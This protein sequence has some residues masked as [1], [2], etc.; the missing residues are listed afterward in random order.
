MMNETLSHQ[1][2][3]TTSY[4]EHALGRFRD[5]VTTEVTHIKVLVE[6]S[7][8]N[9]E[10]A[11]RDVKNV[12]EEA[13]MEANRGVNEVQ[14]TLEIMMA[15]H[16]A[17]GN[18]LAISVTK[19]NRSITDRVWTL[20]RDVTD[21]I[22]KSQGIVSRGQTANQDSTRAMFDNSVA[23]VVKSSN[24]AVNEHFAEIQDKLTTMEDEREDLVPVITEAMQTI[25][26]DGVDAIRT[27]MTV[28]IMAPI[29]G[30]YATLETMIESCTRPSEK[31]SL[32]ESM[33]PAN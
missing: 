14:K 27:D 24:D 17:I 22:R 2:D 15:G 8:T 30:Q 6:D 28:T 9:N 18:S 16:K 12:A 10:E 5:D 25:V 3:E 20:R 29:K 21:E 32:F 7:F 31:S 19:L 1:G 26:R 11:L 13:K 23:K 33:S 4:V